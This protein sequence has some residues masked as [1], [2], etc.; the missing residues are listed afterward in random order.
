MARIRFSR[1]EDYELRLSRLAGR[2]EEIA[3][4]AIY[5]GADIITNAIRANIEGLAAVDDR[6]GAIAYQKKAPAPLTRTAK[7]GLLDGLG[8]TPMQDDGGYYNVKV[9]FDG[10]N[11]IPTRKYPNGQPNQL[12]ARSLESG[13]SIAQKH[14]FIRPAINASRKA[15]E[16]KMAE[17]LDEE[18]L[19]RVIEGALDRTSGV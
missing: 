18:P 19:A 4:K 13:S 11:D 15:A 8:I 12:I 1:L 6:A 16:A 7:Q 2:T 5:A 14:P 17:V 9:G 3:G 10:Y